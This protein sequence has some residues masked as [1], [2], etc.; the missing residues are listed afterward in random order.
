MTELAKDIHF[1]MQN[2]SSVLPVLFRRMFNFYL[3]LLIRQENIVS[4]IP[5]M[6][7]LKLKSYQMLLLFDI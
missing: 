1:H 5:A 3:I 2:F 6:L 4:G 7:T